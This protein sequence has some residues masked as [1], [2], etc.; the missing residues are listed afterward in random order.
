ML[1]DDK[2]K[3]NIDREFE[4]YKRSIKKSNILVLGQTGVGK[5]SLVN[6]VFGEDI[7]KISNVKPETRGFNRYDSPILPINIIDSEGYELSNS[8]DFITNFKTFY[9]EK[10]VDGKEQIH[11]AWYCIN[12]SG[13][14]VLP[15]DI[16]IIKFLVDHL[17]IPTAVVFTQCD[18]DDEEGSTAKKLSEVIRQAFGSKMQCF[19]ISTDSDLKLDLEMLISWSANNISDDNI[20]AAFILSQKASLKLKFQAAQKII[21]E[22]ALASASIH[23]KAIPVSA[24]T[25]LLSFQVAM[26]RKIFNIYGLNQG[27][28]PIVDILL[29]EKVLYIVNKLVVDYLPR[30]FSGI[31]PKLVRV[32]E[33]VMPSGLTYMLGYAVCKTAESLYEKLID[34]LLNEGSISAILTEENIA[35]FMKG[36]NKQCANETA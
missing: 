18:L 12:V 19:Q 14:R 20:K 9:D 36:Y 13:A 31:N 26:A 8:Q 30:I 16:E 21:N 22:S 15:F 28:P 4:E 33:T 24:A 7:A 29:S 3:Q 23:I 34:G 11:L 32:V 1:Y 27:I 35:A 2:L 5:S 10:F 17:K 6:L 25:Q